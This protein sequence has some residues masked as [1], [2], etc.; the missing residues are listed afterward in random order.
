[1]AYD[2]LGALN[3]ANAEAASA[4]AAS[5]TAKGGYETANASRKGANDFYDTASNDLGVKDI[6]GKLQTSR[7]AVQGT[8]TALNNVD[9]S[10]TGRTSGSLVSEAQRQ[11]LSAM[12]RTPL[13]QQFGQLSDVYG[14]NQSDYQNVM[15]QAQSKA[16]MGYQSQQDSLASLQ[17]IWNMAN[18]NYGQAQGKATQAASDAQW[19]QGFQE[20]QRQFEAQ[21]AAARAAMDAQNRQFQM[22]LQNSNA[23]AAKT[24]ASQ[25]KYSQGQIN[26]A[27]WLNQNGGAGSVQ[28]YKTPSLQSIM[29]QQNP[30]VNLGNGIVNAAQST[31]K[32]LGGWGGSLAKLF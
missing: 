4:K 3:S 30:L 10:V 15:S 28:N 17:N 12:E 27:N 32:L 2:Y 16:G 26:S 23:A 18:T 31:G 1:M 5:D 19:W 22:S 25:A 29:S 11:R 9:S 8:Q 14:N 21:Q 24:A 13:M 6:Y 20:Q 7:Q